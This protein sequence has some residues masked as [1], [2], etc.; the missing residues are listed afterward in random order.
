MSK[1]ESKTPCQAPVQVIEPSL[2]RPS[3]CA[4]AADQHPKLFVD[5][6]QVAPAAP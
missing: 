6:P 3:S 4:G 2:K 1:V 5:V